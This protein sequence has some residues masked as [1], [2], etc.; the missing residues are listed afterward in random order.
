MW[1]ELVPYYNCLRPVDLV[2]VPGV[3]R[4]QRSVSTAR[5]K[6]GHLSKHRYEALL[7]FEQFIEHFPLRSLHHDIA[8]HGRNVLSVTV[9]VVN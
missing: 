5:A 8:Q 7:F 9:K 4:N 6:V 2:L 1:R 3:T